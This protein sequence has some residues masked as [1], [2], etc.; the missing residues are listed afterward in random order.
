MTY[1]PTTVAELG[2]WFHN[3]VLPDGTQTA[4]DHFL[5]SDFPRNKWQCLAPHLPA[6][7]T[8]WT[9][10]D[11]GCNA[12]YY[13]LELAKR[14][15]HITAIDVNP[16]YL[17]QAQWACEQFGLQERVTFQQTGVYELAQSS[18]KYDLILFLGVFYHL[19]YPTLALDIVAEKT[20]RLLVFQTLTMPG[21]EVYPAEEDMD[22]DHRE[23]MQ[24]PGWPQMAFIEHRLCGDPTNWWALNHAGILA[25]LRSCGLRT[26]ATPGHELYISE[27]DPEHPSCMTTWNCWEYEAVTKR[28]SESG[29]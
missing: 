24:E 12:G 16:F 8:G 5:G 10:L 28:G 23:A 4:P 27:P 26:L 22:I 13:T 21:M 18:E 19:R 29:E 14:G 2:P 25:L 20:N 3:I 15:A 9:A 7:L 11:I 1:N 6:D 17:A